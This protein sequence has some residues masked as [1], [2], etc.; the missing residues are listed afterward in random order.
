MN[1][2]STCTYNS[3]HGRTWK[4]AYALVLCWTDFYFSSNFKYL[5]LDLAGISISVWIFRLFL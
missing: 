3:L 4:G 2:Q 5:G 1:L